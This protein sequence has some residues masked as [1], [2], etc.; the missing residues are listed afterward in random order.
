VCCPVGLVPRKVVAK[1]RDALLS[2]ADVAAL[3][4]I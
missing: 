3:S 2:D 4:K 1:Q